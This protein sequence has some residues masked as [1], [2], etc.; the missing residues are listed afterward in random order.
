MKQ[1]GK[2]TRS[3]RRKGQVLVVVLLGMTL[4]TGLIF[5]V[6]NVGYQVNTRLEM[7]NAVDA[8]AI[9]GGAWMAR[10]MNVVAMNNVTQTRLMA[11]AIVLDSLPLAAEMTIAE[12]TGKEDLSNALKA[13]GAVGPPFT[14]YEKDNFYREG[15]AELYRQMTYGSDDDK[16]EHYAKRQL[17]LLE[18]IDQ[19]FDTGDE[20]DPEGGYDITEDTRWLGAGGSGSAP[21]GRIWQAIVALDVFSQAIAESADVL[22]Q[23]NAV[24]FGKADGADAAF[25]T[26][27]LPEFPGNRSKF[28]DFKPLFTQRL[29]IVNDRRG[30]RESHAVLRSGIVEKLQAS[31]DVPWDL[32]KIAVRGGAIPDFTYPY[33]LGPFAK[34]YQWRDYNHDQEGHWWEPNYD[35]FRIGYTSYGPLEKAVRTV[36][37]QFGQAS[38]SKGSA[39]TSRLS[40]HLRSVAKLKLAYMF[41]LSAP[42]KM[43]YADKWIPDYAD[44]KGF[45]QGRNGVETNETTARFLIDNDKGGASAQGDWRESSANK[46]YD[47]SSLETTADGASYTWTARLPYKGEHRV[48]AWWSEA[49][50]GSDRNSAARYTINH[51]FGQATVTKNQDRRAGRWVELGVWEFPAG[52]SARVTVTHQ[53]GADKTVADAV[54][55]VPI[56][57][58]E[59]ENDQPNR[60]KS[61]VMKTRYYRVHVKSTVHWDDGGH[62]MRTYETA[63]PTP[64]FTPKRW[65]SHQLRS[66]L[67]ESRTNDLGKPR[68]QPLYR[69]ILEYKGWK[70]IGSGWE[71]LTDHVWVRKRPR[72]V[73]HDYDLRLPPRYELEADGSLK[74]KTDDNGNLV[75]DKNGEPQPIPIPYIIYTVEWRTFG[76][77]EIRDEHEVDDILAGASSSDLPAPFLIDTTGEVTAN[78]LYT[79]GNGKEREGVRVDPFTYLGVV[80][81][82]STAPVWPARFSAANPARSMY[83]LAEVKL[84]NNRSW[85]LWTQHWRVQLK[86]VSGLDEWLTEMNAGI[87]DAPDTE[88]MVPA[89]EA[90]KAHEYMSAMPAD[91]VELYLD[92]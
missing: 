79:Q 55:F 53:A 41:G 86:P 56:S 6:Y 14:P 4:L 52:E 67:P 76:G 82:G 90:E 45:V 40:Y 13:W 50:D 92:H 72:T 78:V 2:Q 42:Q 17:G 57:R 5:Y 60:K 48:Y 54:H 83:T 34:V 47:D 16:N 77:I 19:T 68:I 9:S 44:A 21:H 31:A 91:M 32:R 59:N 29:R 80:R 84:F 7:Q 33:R 61:L 75:L 49:R 87:A 24:R 36:V 70:D 26:P 18:K 22:S 27:V 88:G 62:W 89:T 46:E 64:D 73:L 8:T 85:G 65:H 28:Y 10:S 25:L 30:G 11:L 23:A 43:Q 81:K 74:Y 37:Q 12:E 66:P 38:H 35:V 20:R 58:E 3:Y 51:A 39:D 15:L 63:R 69:W 1:T 71:K